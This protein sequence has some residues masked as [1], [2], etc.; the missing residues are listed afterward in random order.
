[1]GC[2]VA[3]LGAVEFNLEVA[4]APGCCANT[5]LDSNQPVWT[6]AETQTPPPSPNKNAQTSPGF[7]KQQGEALSAGAAAL[8][9]A[10][11][12]ALARAPPALPSEPF[13]SVP[14]EERVGELLC[15]P[16]AVLLDFF[17][18]ERAAVVEVGG[19]W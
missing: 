15:P 11:S 12:A 19:G 2:I 5:Q 4:I 6:A 18:A 13:Y 1:M 3:A 8:D 16:H 9:A 17:R 10:A 7:A 14:A